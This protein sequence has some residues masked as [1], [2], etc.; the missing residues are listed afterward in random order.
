MKRERGQYF[1]TGNPF[2]HPQTRGGFLVYQLQTGI[3]QTAHGLEFL[4]LNL[5]VPSKEPIAF[6][7]NI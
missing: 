4:D 2:N 5:V 6:W 1:T 3:I 7:M